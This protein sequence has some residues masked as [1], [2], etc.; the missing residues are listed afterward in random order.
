MNHVFVFFNKV[1]F[2]ISNGNNVV[3]QKEDIFRYKFSDNILQ[4]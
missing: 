4:E 3:L 2:K 1:S